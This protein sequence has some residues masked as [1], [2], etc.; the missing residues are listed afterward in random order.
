[1][2]TVIISA[3]FIAAIVLIFFA[4]SFINK[5]NI[6]KKNQKLLSQFSHA[7]TSH[8]LSFSSQEILRNKIIGLDGIHR[9]FVMVNEKEECKVVALDEV[10]KCEVVKFFE[11]YKMGDPKNNDTERHLTSIEL[12]FQF[13]K[14]NDPVSIAFYDN[15]IHPVYE[16]EPMEAKAK[17]WE[18]LLSKLLQAPQELRA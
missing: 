1:M 7:G 11:T 15:M 2:S 8:G 4:F 12:L 3:I 17:D 10:K 6:K 14:N 18:I 16:A 9:K 5:R 13:K